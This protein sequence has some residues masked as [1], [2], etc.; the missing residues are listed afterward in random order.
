MTGLRRLLVAALPISLLACGGRDTAADAR[1]DSLPAPAVQPGDTL[2][3]PPAM[4]S[5]STAG[6]KATAPPAGS[7]QSADSARR[8]G[9][10][11]TPAPTGKPGASGTLSSTDLGVVAGA[12]A[13]Q[14]GLQVMP[15]ENLAPLALTDLRALAQRQQ[16][17]HAAERRYT[18][19]VQPLGASARDG[20][21]IRVVHA[22]ARGWAA[23][24]TQAFYPGRSCV[25]WLGTSAEEARA[26]RTEANALLGEEG[27][28]VC[29]RAP[30]R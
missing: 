28:P 26:P 3:V 10:T 15:W 14:G 22:S 27:V 21:T 20:W 30:S 19:S 16:R 5:D 6:T 7:G 1:A 2:A 9:A 29:D 23:V 17:T 4:T 25:V 12:A 18:T 13:Q 11:T 8:P 24:A